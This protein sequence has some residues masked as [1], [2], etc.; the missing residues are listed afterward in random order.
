MAK[1]SFLI[2][3]AE[4]GKQR[5]ID[6]A[7]LKIVENE[8]TDK[9]GEELFFVLQTDGGD[10]FSAVAIM[11]ILRSKFK[12]LYVLI[13]DKA[14][15]AGTLMSLGTDIIYMQT[16]SALGPLDLPMEHPKDNS[17]ISAL[18]FSNAISTLSTLSQSIAKKIH[19]ILRDEEEGIVLSKTEAA[20]LAFKTATDFV[21]PIVQQIDPYHLQKSYRELGIAR[22]Y[23]VDLL[24]KGMM[25]KNI[26]QAYRTARSLVHNYPVH[27]YSI[28]SEEAKT[29]LKL[30]V[31]DLE[32]LPEWK[33][34]K[35]DF[36]EHNKKW[37]SIKY[38]E[39][40]EPAQR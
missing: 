11:N 34:I 1:K 19:E 21:A 35:A 13:P 24:L 15:S 6:N 20:K 18:D 40:N 36:D 7:C 4:G 10:P 37:R 16:K 8:L 27:E 26:L 29:T 23:A 17:R 22:N 25:K 2:F 28:F 14:K 30:K 33:L 3:V 31:E 38:I 5:S 9:S 12:R 32:L 39:K